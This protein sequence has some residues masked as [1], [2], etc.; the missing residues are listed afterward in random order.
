V[1]TAKAVSARVLD[2]GAAADAIAYVA[3]RPAQPADIRVGLR[4]VHARY[5]EAVTGLT[6]A[7]WPHQV[8]RVSRVTATAVYY[9]PLDAPRATPTYID[10]A[11]FL[12]TAVGGVLDPEGDP[13]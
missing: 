5:L 3:V 6:V 7:Q 11:L 13:R 1:T 12:A 10:P 2:P 9:R 4:F 8:F